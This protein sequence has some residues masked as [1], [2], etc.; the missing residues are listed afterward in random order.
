MDTDGRALRMKSG[1][2]ATAARRL[3]VGHDSRIWQ[4]IWSAVAR[5]RRDTAFVR[6]TAFNCSINYRAG[7]SGVGP[8]CGIPAAVQN[9]E[10]LATITDIYSL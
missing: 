9:A 2:R 6:T 4:S 3:R 7:E 10:V 1:R 8:A 5:R